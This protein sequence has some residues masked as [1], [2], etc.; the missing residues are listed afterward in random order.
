MN[1]SAKLKEYTTECKE[2]LVKLLAHLTLTEIQEL[3]REFVQSAGYDDDELQIFMR[4]AFLAQA[5]C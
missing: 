5:N 3:A 4:G 2:P 1:F